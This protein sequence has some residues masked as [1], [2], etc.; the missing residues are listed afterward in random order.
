MTGATISDLLRV[1]SLHAAFLGSGGPKDLDLCLIDPVHDGR[2]SFESVSSFL[3]ILRELRRRWAGSFIVRHEHRGL[4]VRGQ[5]LLHLL[6]YPSYQHLARW[7]PP[8]FLAYLHDRGRFI[9]GSNI[10]LQAAYSDYRCRHH[11]RP[12][13]L[14]ADQLYHYSELAVSSIVYLVAEPGLFPPVVFH[15]N[16]LYV[17]RFGVT[18][19]LTDVLDP[20]API[21]FWDWDELI[22]FLEAQDPKPSRLLSQLATREKSGNSVSCEALVEGFLRC[23]R[24]FDR[25]LLED[26]PRTVRQLLRRLEESL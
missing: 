7:E 18:E 23:L 14:T 17:L 2:Q 1:S 6:Y 19:L 25:C 5:P 11:F 22:A 24:L 8:S 12:G 3:P 4:A 15:E 16:L 26:P 21:A 20:H 9:N 10:N 13:T